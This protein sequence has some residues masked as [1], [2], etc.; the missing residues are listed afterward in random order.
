MDHTYE[1][2]RNAV[3]NILAGREKVAN[4]P[5]QYSWLP[6]GVAEVFQRRE[7][8]STDP[9]LLHQGPQLSA[10]DRELLR[11]VFWELFRQGIIT[12]G[13]NEANAQFPWFKVS[14]FGKTILDNQTPYFFH[15]LESY[16]KVIRSNVPNINEITL[17]YLQEAMQSFRS[18]CMLAATVMLGV[19][20]SWKPPNRTK[21]TAPDLPVLPNRERSSRSSESSRRRSTNTCYVISHRKSRKTSTSTSPGYSR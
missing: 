11:E 9:S 17:F 3:I 7:G 2:I 4:Y 1:E 8:T 18:G 19:A 21:S 14:L 10:I 16:T 6:G 15:D 12:L 5:N 20:C 13:T